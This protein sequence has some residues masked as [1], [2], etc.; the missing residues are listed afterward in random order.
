MKANRRMRPIFAKT[1]P[2]LLLLLH[3]GAVD[4]QRLPLGP[5]GAEEGGPLQRLGYTPM[6][7]GAAP[8]AAGELRASAWIGY[9]NLFEQDSTADHEMYLDMERMVTALTVRYGVAEGLEVGGRATLSTAWG[10]F[11]DGFMIRFHR[12]LAL[13]VRNRPHYPDGSYGAWLRDGDHRTLVEV[14][15]RALSLDDVRL[16][17]KWTVA[18]GPETRGTLSARAVARVPTA[19]PTV[20]SERVDVGVMLLGSLAWRG[21]FLHAMAGGSTVRRGPDMVDVLRSR[22]WFGMLGVERPLHERLSAVIELTG[23]TQLVR[24]FHDHD[25]SG[26]PTNLVFGV[27][28]VTEGG[29]RWEVGM[30]EDVPPRGPS[31]DF[32]I[33]L[34][35]SRSW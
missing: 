24:D 29:W 20:G 10:G 13:G 15:K 18:G 1:L 25:V 12:A 7:E 27:V 23:S 3:P 35:L 22:Q 34:G 31:L 9:T 17:A 8:V 32:T 33:Q 14:P 4:A 5:L 2:L 30:Q 26:M 16:F 21:F 11:L 28:G 19:Q 6:V